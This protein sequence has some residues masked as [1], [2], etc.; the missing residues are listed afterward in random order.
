MIV[1]TNL[2]FSVYIN[3]TDLNAGQVY[4]ANT[5]QDAS[6][7]YGDIKGYMYCIME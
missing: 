3:Y 5:A 2:V 1:K 4:Q 7:M 6:L